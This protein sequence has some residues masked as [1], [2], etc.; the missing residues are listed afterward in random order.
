M[1]DH[2]RAE[3]ALAGVRELVAADGGDIVVAS[4]SDDAVRLTLVLETASCAECV[5]P[6]R[7]LETVAL[8]M[9]RAELPGLAAVVIDDPRE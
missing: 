8:D 5:M 2:A 4:T 1:I 3:A 6:R 9:M 7:F